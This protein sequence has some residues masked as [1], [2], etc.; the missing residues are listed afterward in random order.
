M[1]GLKK[2]FP[3]SQRVIEVIIATVIY[4]EVPPHSPK[5]RWMYGWIDG[6]MDGWMDGWVDR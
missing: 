5:M 3:Y 1:A 2:T 6:W 4:K